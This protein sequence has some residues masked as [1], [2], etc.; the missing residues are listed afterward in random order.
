VLLTTEPSL[1]PQLSVSC[2]AYRVSLL[3]TWNL[4]PLAQHGNSRDGRK[5]FPLRDAHLY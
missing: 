2:S 1:Q 5:P 4:G 3:G